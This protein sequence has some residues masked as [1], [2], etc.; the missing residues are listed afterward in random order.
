MDLETIKGEKVPAR[1]KSARTAKLD[2]EILLEGHRQW[3]QSA[4]RHGHRA[5]LSRLN[6]EG[7]D[8][9]DVNLRGAVLNDTNLKDADLLLSDLEGAYLVQANLQGANLLGVKLR[10]ANLHGADLQGASGLLAAELSGTNLTFAKLPPEISPAEDLLYVRR[11]ARHANWLIVCILLISA[12]ASWRILTV[13]DSQIL[14]NASFLPVRGLRNELPLVQFL[15][16]CPVLLSGVYL[17]L[18]LYLQRLWEAMS[19]L[20]AIFGN[21]RRLDASL[22]WLVR[23]PA[24]SH[25]KWLQ[26]KRSPLAGIEKIICI[27]LLYWVAPVTML[28]FWARY[29]TLQDARG[30]VLHVLLITAVISAALYFPRSAVRAFCSSDSIP[31]GVGAPEKART[32][33]RERL[34]GSSLIDL[35]LVPRPSLPPDSLIRPADEAVA[36][37]LQN[38][39]HD[40]LRESDPARE[41]SIRDEYRRSL[42]WPRIPAAAAIGL[43]LLLLSIGTI[44]GVPHG[45]SVAQGV[46]PG[47]P[48]TWAADLFWLVGYDPFAQASEAEISQKPAGWTGAEDEVGRVQ[49]AGLNELR[50][51]YLQGYGAFLV[52]ARLRQADLRYALLSEADLRQANLRGANLQSAALDRARLGG[53][54]LQSAD[55]S[56]ANLIRANLEKADLS[57][58]LLNAALLQDAKLDSAVLYGAKL[59]A[60]ALERANLPQVDLREAD[61]EGA[62]LSMSDLHNAYLS[63]AKMTGARLDQSQLNGAIFMGADLRHADLNSSNF[64]GAVLSAADLSGANLQNTDFRGAVGLRASQICSASNAQGAQLDDALAADVA[65]RCPALH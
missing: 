42:Q 55:L 29:L 33:P 61:L 38:A 54:T 36:E 28:L 65:V 21:G 3:V 14:S 23:W 64:Q 9:T 53:A 27:L 34:R 57:F 4:G 37:L 12:F 45:G 52:K 22:P 62:N 7:A 63:S 20:P 17:W 46:G 32:E 2:L 51:R 47:S 30:T 48:R 13:S 31:F 44:A 58:A 49:G 26:E 35:P 24:H 50:L 10:E 6:L 40:S 25:F 8:L 41:Q 60:A 39:S 19:A 18:H 1:N 43:F 11:R 56:R 15:L 5:D 16:F 59:R